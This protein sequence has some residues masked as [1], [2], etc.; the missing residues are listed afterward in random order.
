MLS[1][2]I[3]DGWRPA[4][5]ETSAVEG[6]GIAQLWEA[7]AEHRRHLSAT[8]DLDVRRERRVRDEL[9]RIVA[10]R[11][12]ERAGVVAEGSRFDEAVSA[13]LARTDDPWH[14]TGVLIG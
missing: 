7:V 4:I 2:Q 6:R 13:V 3:G 1:L 8:G 12:A 11:L 10:A 9:R 5:V 14:A